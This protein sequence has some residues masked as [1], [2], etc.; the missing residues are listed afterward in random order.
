MFFRR[1]QEK[2][3][4]KAQMDQGIALSEIA[5]IVLGH[6]SSEDFQSSQATRDLVGNLNRQGVF[7]EVHAAFW[8]EE[9][10]YR[11]VFEPISC[12]EVYVVPHFISEGYFTK[13]VIPRE[14]KLT[15]KM[16]ERDGFCI[17]YCDPV[18]SHRGMTD[19]LMQRANELAH[20]VNLA[21]TSL[22]ILGHGTG[23]NKDSAKAVCEQVEKIQERKEGFGEVLGVYLDEVPLLSDWYELSQFEN[24][25][26]LPYFIAEGLHFSRDLPKM[27]GM[28]TGG[29]KQPYNIRSR[30]V[31]CALP[32]GGDPAMAEMVID[33]VRGFEGG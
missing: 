15:G 29:A 24:V 18:G 28:K 26:V 20:G 25:I 6:G 33:Q 12:A 21:E 2:F 27:L 14:L 22:L 11:D 9:P 32:V 5:V 8:K 3:Y 19:L 16:T 30:K 13:E 31:F 23:R 10:H 17:H 1:K 7:A 4:S